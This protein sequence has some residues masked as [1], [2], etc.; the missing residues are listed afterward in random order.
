MI[1][2]VITRIPN[3]LKRNMF[4]P[5]CYSLTLLTE[6]ECSGGCELK[7]SHRF[8]LFDSN[9]ELDSS[10]K[11]KHYSKNISAHPT[12]VGD[13]LSF[14]SH[15]S[16]TINDI[17]DVDVRLLP[18]E[19]CLMCL[20]AV[21]RIQNKSNDL[22][23]QSLQNN[24]RCSL[25][26][27][28]GNWPLHY[29]K[30]EHIT[31]WNK[32]DI[33]IDPLQNN[34]NDNNNHDCSWMKSEKFDLLLLTTAACAD[35]LSIKS[36]LNLTGHFQFFWDRYE[37]KVYASILRHIHN[38]INEL[39]CNQLAQLAHI[40]SNIRHN[41][42][43]MCSDELLTEIK[44]IQLAI[45][46]HLL[47]KTGMLSS[48]D[49]TVAV[50][51]VYDIHWILTKSQKITLV[52]AIYHDLILNRSHWN[53]YTVT[54]LLL[55]MCKLGVCKPSIIK[56]CLNNISRKLR[57][58]K[59]HPGVNQSH[60]VNSM[61]AVL[62]NYTVAS[63]GINQNI[64]DALQ[65]F[66]EPPYINLSDNQREIHHNILD[67][68]KIFATDRVRKLFD[69]ISQHVTSQQIVDF[70][71]L[72]CLAQ[73]IYSLSLFGY[74]ADSI[75]GQ[76]NEAEKKLRDNIHTISTM[77]TEVADFTKLSRFINMAKCLVSP[78][79]RNSS[80][81]EK[82]SI[83]SFPRGDWRFYYHCGLG[84]LESNVINDP[85]ISANLLHKSRCLDQLC[86]MLFENKHEFNI[87]RM[88]RLQCIQC[89]NGDNGNIP[90]FA[91][92]LF[93]KMSTQ[94]TDKY[95][96]VI[97]IVHEQRDLVV[98]GPLLSLLSFYRETQRLPVVTFNFSV[99][100][101]SSKQGKIL[102]VQ[103]FLQEISKKLDEVDHFSLPEIHTTD[104]I[105]QFD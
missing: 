63:T 28:D 72:K 77:S 27:S 15:P 54:F 103:K 92:I 12:A 61:L 87:M 34:N 89:S 21:L 9:P 8:H 16:T 90:Y 80:E 70:N 23:I 33:G 35:S 67:V 14:V 22:T 6:R 68:H 88:H 48:V 99:W 30:L 25:T 62:A 52:S 17:L 13:L 94:H 76:Y 7:G 36:L 50:R 84:L 51:L 64:E 95:N 100:L 82:L 74:K 91:D 11:S 46:T 101:M 24:L 85:L 44:L 81:N 65:S 79:S 20:E 66:I 86:Q 2:K 71:S 32:F 26:S 31:R 73:I 96:Y 102:I 5:H 43:S 1:S 55:H 19:A 18:S 40:L 39:S 57:I 69:D 10:I 53:L 78:L 83:L 56:S 45:S 98:K 29:M 97:C 4:Y 60:W 105:L 59:Y 41:S 75:I 42:M 58:S 47:S 38:Q 104:I 37:P 93:Q 49:P 3:F